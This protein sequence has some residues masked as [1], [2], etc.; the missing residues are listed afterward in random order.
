MVCETQNTNA[1]A[2]AFYRRV[3]FEL[4]GIDLSYYSNEDVTQGEVALF[5]KLRLT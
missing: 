1:P 5:M 2:I 3:G 4:D